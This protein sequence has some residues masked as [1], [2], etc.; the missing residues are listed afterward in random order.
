[1][2]PSGSSGVA[3]RRG[4]YEVTV[5]GQLIFSKLKMRCFPVEKQ[6]IDDVR[7]ATNGVKPKKLGSDS[8]V[9]MLLELCHLGHE[10]LPVRSRNIADLA[11]EFKRQAAPE[12]VDV[13]VEGAGKL[14]EAEELA[15]GQVEGV[16]E[17]LELTQVGGRAEVKGEE[18]LEGGVL[19]LLRVGVVGLED[20]QQSSTG[21]GE[22]TAECL[23]FVDVF[24]A[25]AVD[26]V[27]EGIPEARKCSRVRTVEGREKHVL[28]NGGADEPGR[29][30]A[31]VEAG[32]TVAASELLHQVLVLLHH[33]GSWRR[34]AVLK[35][36]LWRRCQ[37]GRKRSL[38]RDGRRHGGSC[39]VHR[40]SSEQCLWRDNCSG[41]ILSACPSGVQISGH[42]GRR[43][44]FE[45][46]INGQLIF[47]KLKL[48]GFPD[49]NQVVEQVKRAT[50]GDNPNVLEDSQ[51]PG[52]NLL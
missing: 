42:D 14:A 38:D 26:A 21:A 15:G 43:G 33:R 32:R 41:A 37:Q 45:V 40:R 51:S 12:R 20:T 30:A 6:V 17:F 46:T 48:H 47:S 23:K 18:T 22:Q 52:C 29:I 19:F 28:E 5:N 49:E 1:R 34:A 8:G 10:R 4:A 39:A 9:E 36:A 13:A 16:C 3:G 27:N 35:R 25:G 2:V 31:G 50:N 44:S 7:K 11:L 24:E